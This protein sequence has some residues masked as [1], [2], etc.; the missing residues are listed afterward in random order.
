MLIFLI[1]GGFLYAYSGF[2][3]NKIA[4]ILSELLLNSF[5]FLLVASIYAGWEND[6]YQNS[7]FIFFNNYYIFTSYTFFL[8][9]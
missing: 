8:K 7:Y 4:I 6:F 1:L 5:F 3:K 2:S 9:I